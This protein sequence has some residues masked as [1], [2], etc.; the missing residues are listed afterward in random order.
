MRSQEICEFGL[1]EKSD[2]MHSE[3]QEKI[4]FY[5]VISLVSLF[6][7]SCWTLIGLYIYF[8]FSSGLWV[9]MLQDHF[10]ILV[11]LPFGAGFSLVVVILLG[12]TQ[13]PIEFEAIGFK[14]RGASGPIVLWC[15]VFLSIMAS[16]R[17]LW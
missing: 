6:I 2:F 9:K 1:K 15:L 3:K 11:V 17:I 16:V 5:S 12:A 4:K 8:G 13:G 10:P 14:F 7:I